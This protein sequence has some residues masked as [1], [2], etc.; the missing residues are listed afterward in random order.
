MGGISRELPLLSKSVSSLAKVELST[1]AR[2]PN[3]LSVSAVFY[4]SERFPREIRLAVALISS[5]GCRARVTRSQRTQT[6]R[7]DRTGR[8]CQQPAKLAKISQIQC[9]RAS[10]KNAISHLGELKVSRKLS[11][12]RSEFRV[13]E[14]RSGCEG[15]RSVVE[16]FSTDPSRDQILKK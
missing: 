10:R 11:R 15:R 13:G 12:V 16:P 2:R 6:K 9:D 1:L 7:H 4:S 8:G 5:T 3:S 14:L